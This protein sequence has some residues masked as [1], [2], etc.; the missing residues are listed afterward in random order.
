M[1]GHWG[2]FLAGVGR[3]DWYVE[4]ELKG[5]FYPPA[6]A[7]GG[8]QVG[9]YIGRYVLGRGRSVR[10]LSLS[11]KAFFFA[12]SSHRYGGCTKLAAAASQ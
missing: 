7:V 4:F 10:R 2:H 3:T 6:R 1:A 8:R 9:R 11:G 12:R 5:I